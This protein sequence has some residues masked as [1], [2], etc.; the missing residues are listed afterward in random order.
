EISNMLASTGAK[1][2]SPAD[3]GITED[4]DEEGGE[5]FEENALGKARFY[6]RRAAKMIVVADDSGLTVD[7]LEGE[8]GVKTRRWG[9]G[10]TASDE[11][12][13]DFFMNRM[14]RESNRK[15]AFVC[16]AA[17]RFP[18]CSEEVFT[19]GTPGSICT[20]QKAAIKAGIPLSSVFL[21]DGYD[22]VYASMTDEEKNKLSHRGKAFAEI[23]NYLKTQS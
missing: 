16:A 12:W 23:L 5:S 22:K 7:A 13:L 8:L 15:A 18:D 11:E 6:G 14:E 21:P 20:E 2:F 19:K 3:L 4:F 9:A 17:L 10:E 1:F